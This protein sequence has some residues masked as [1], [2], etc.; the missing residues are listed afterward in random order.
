MRANELLLRRL[1]IRDRLTPEEAEAVLALP[2]VIATYD[3][4][5]SIVR[6]GE[7]Q[8]KSRLVINGWIARSNT[9]ADGRRQITQLHIAGDFFDLHSFLMKRLE[10]D[11]VALTQSTVAEVDHSQL[12]IFT[13]RFPHLTRLLW[14]L[15]LI[16]A[17]TYREW[18]TLMGRADAY[19][20]VAFILCE[21]YVRQAAVGVAADHVMDFPLTQEELGDVC[22]LTAIHINRVLQ[23]LRRA[24]LI[25]TADRRMRF[26]DW[27]RLVAVA[28]FDPTYLSLVPLPR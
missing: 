19:Q 17:A 27:D 23:E 24:G 25:V 21:L 4:R 14:M 22:G 9:L 20:H 10:H 13:E 26:P 8:S 7:I 6:A 11:V 16:D 3:R 1:E 28:Q 2:A 18:L 5:Q 15:T 12:K